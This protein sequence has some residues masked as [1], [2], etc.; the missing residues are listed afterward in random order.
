M[1]QLSAKA[2][3]GLQQVSQT[4]VNLLNRETQLRDQIWVQEFMLFVIG[5][6]EQNEFEMAQQ[7][8]MTTSVLP[9]CT[10]NS[11]K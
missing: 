10:T 4:R 1:S 5:I 9:T 3:A 6:D 7:R 11:L 8:Q 2:V